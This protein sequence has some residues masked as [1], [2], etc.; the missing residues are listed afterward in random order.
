MPAKLVENRFLSNFQMK[1][2]IL[3]VIGIIILGFIQL[4]LATD[5]IY[6]Y[7]S[8][9]DTTWVFIFAGQSNMVGQGRKSELDPYEIESVPNIKIWNTNKNKWGTISNVLNTQFGPEVG[10]AYALGTQYPTK[11][12]RFIKL[13]VGGTSLAVDWD[14]AKSGSLYNKLMNRVHKALENLHNKRVP[15]QVKAV[16]WMQGEQDSKDS[17]HPEHANAYEHNLKNLIGKFRSDMN[18]PELPFI[19]GRIH[20]KLIHAKPHAGLDFG[21]ANVVRKAMAKVDSTKYNT[22]MINTD[23]LPLIADHIHFNTKGLII[24]GNRFVQSWIRFN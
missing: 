15:F 12:I 24:L 9:S 23:D 18:Q 10:A 8:K 6:A 20:N 4:C 17:R 21:Q 16:F 13:A 19:F 1:S 22:E 3:R 5:V 14:P 11:S 2:W 7:P